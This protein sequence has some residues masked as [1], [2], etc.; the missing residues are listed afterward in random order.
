M[1][2]KKRLGRGLEALIS[3]EE[4]KEDSIKDIKINDIEPNKKQ[5][6]K[7]FDDSKLNELAESIKKHGIVQP[8]IVKKEDDIYRIIA[9]E[10]RWRAAKIA[11]LQT[12][13]AILK[14]LDDRNC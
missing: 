4:D 1:N 9:G 11:G 6:R 14:E 10:R 2:G 8:I 7:T 3:I 13:P 12:V 5:P